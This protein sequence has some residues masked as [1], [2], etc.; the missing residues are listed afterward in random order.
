MGVM[1]GFSISTP[2]LTPLPPPGGGVARCASQGDLLRGPEGEL[3]VQSYTMLTPMYIRA[4]GPTKTSFATLNDQLP[5]MSGVHGFKDFLCSDHLLESFDGRIY[6]YGSV[7]KSK[8]VHQR[9]HEDEH[10]RGN[11]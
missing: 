1:S 8:F 9:I 10:Y 3:Q 4:G 11:P 2:A 5:S 6:S 7:L